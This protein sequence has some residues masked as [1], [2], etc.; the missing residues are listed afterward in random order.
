MATSNRA[1]L[2]SIKLQAGT[3]N[4]YY[5]TWKWGKTHVENYKVIWYYATGQGVWF[6]G[7][8]TTATA[9][10]STYSPPE[11]AKK[12][13]VKVKPVAKTYTVGTGKTKKTGPYWT[14]AWSQVKKLTLSSTADISAPSVPSV[15]IV[16]TKLTATIDYYDQPTSVVSHIEFQVVKDN[17]TVASTG[18]AKIKYNQA[19]YTCTIPP[20]GEYKVRA[21]C[22]K[23]TLYTKSVREPRVLN[24][25][26]VPVYY[27]RTETKIDA[28]SDWSEYSSPIGAYPGKVTGDISVVASQETQVKITWPKVSGATGYDIEYTK[29]KSMFGKSSS[30]V[31]TDSLDSIATT[32]YISSL[33]SGSTYYFRI[34][35]KNSS[36]SGKW[37]S[38]VSCTLA[39]TPGAPTTWTY[40]NSAKIGD[41]VVLN[42]THNSQD[43]S[44]QQSASIEILVNNEKPATI[45]FINGK[46]SKYTLATANYSDGDVIYWR[47]K[48]VGLANKNSPYSTQ[49][50]ITLYEAPEVNASLSFGGEWIWDTFNF[51]EDT[52][53]TAKRAGGT[54]TDTIESF[55]FMIDIL[56]TPETQ[57]VLS[58]DVRIVSN[59]TYETMDLIGNE[60]QVLEG[61]EIYSGY[62]SPDY[63]N[64]LHI[65]LNAGDIDLE[66]GANYTVNVIAAMDSG[67][68]AECSTTF[69]VNWEDKEYE[70]DA[71]VAFDNTVFAA[72][73]RPF[74]EDEDG[75]EVRECSFSVYR[76][77]YNGKFTAIATNIRGTDGATV[78]DP[79]PSL[80]YA[81]Y[82]VV[83]MTFETGAVSYTD[84]PAIPV[85]HTSI[86]M[87]WD[88][89]WTY[90]DYS[91]SDE[92]EQPAWT[93]SLLDLPYDIDVSADN[94]PDVALVEYI[95]R[96]HPV[97]YYG[98]QRGESASW[99]CDIRKEDSETLYQ[100]RRLSAYKGDVYVREPSGIG[101]WANVKV[102]YQETHNKTTIPV[103]FTI[104]RVEGGV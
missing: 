47:V 51:E 41:S 45:K 25:R 17:S 39:T 9:K 68:V 32:R 36:G 72:Y 27:Y 74:I 12:I 80:D 89:S 85:G 43:G 18:R 53:Y 103:T 101:Y 3:D 59:S 55:P 21:R 82:R 93:G 26:Y 30:E 20:G 62:F 52:I 73:I 56:A 95:G 64:E 6:V 14:A 78:T 11:N 13:K 69:T 70:P 94:S 50:Q 67:L 19:T 7:S 16:G 10:Q 49:R 97:S 75:N 35:A 24:D 38:I 66:P 2:S 5:V 99:K 92:P 23:E 65:M 77:E 58:F 42:W 91:I 81:R 44:K 54:A 48:T 57:K 15:E 102:S 8:D 60:S 71:D 90:F 29:N 86:I 1:V 28:I 40:S 37:S 34:R 87:Q 61:S 33:D 63:G 46:T 98:T 83:C 84:I 88:E 31:Q 104:T 76:R 100:L 4:L 96:E 22:V 79:H